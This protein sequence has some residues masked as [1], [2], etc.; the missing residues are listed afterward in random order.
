MTKQNENKSINPIVAAVTGAVVGAG[1]AIAGTVAL[2][3]EKNIEK[4]KKMMTNVKDQAVE[5]KKNVQE[6]AQDKKIEVEKKVEEEKKK[7]KQVVNSAKNSIDK[8]TKDVNEA[9]KTI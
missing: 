7:V 9:V 6:Q 2:K 1:L 8:A 4:V 5:F 3:D